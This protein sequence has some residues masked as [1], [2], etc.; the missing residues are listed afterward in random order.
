VSYKIRPKSGGTLAKY[1]KTI[2][3]WQRRNKGRKGLVIQIGNNSGNN[4]NT[5]KK[6]RRTHG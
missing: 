4:N 1:L 3:D 2:A 6:R 5:K